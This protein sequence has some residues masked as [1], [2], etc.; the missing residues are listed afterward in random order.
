MQA[1]EFARRNL[2]VRVNCICPGYFPSVSSIYTLLLCNTACNTALR[3]D[4]QGM[5]VIPPDANTG[6]E[7]HT[8]EFRNKWG[9][10]FGRPGSAVDY[11]QCIFSLVTVSRLVI[12]PETA[13]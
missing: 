1:A 3:S 10:P 6:S 4:P 11:A 7:A 8:A 5:T 13:R 2:G 9:I 12:P